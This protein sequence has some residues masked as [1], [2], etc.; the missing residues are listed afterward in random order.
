[1]KSKGVSYPQEE[2]T[3][4]VN[5]LRPRKFEDFEIVDDDNRT[6][7]HIRIKPSGVLWAPTEAKLWYGV[8]LD[9]FAKYM[10]EKGKRQEK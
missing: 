10:E 3:V 1:L 6:V 2:V 4:S 7:G 8:T 9:E 5:S